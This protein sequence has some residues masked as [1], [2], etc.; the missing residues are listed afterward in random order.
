[1]DS[2]AGGVG[3]GVA[4]DLELIAVQLGGVGDEHDVLVPRHELALPGG[5]PHDQT[6]HAALDLLLH[7]RVVRREVHLAVWQVRGLD[8]GD[9]ARALDLVHA[10]GRLLHAAVGP[11]LGGLALGGE[12]HGEG[13]GGGGSKRCQ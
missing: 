10:R 5:A 1:M 11:F 8:G 12:R 2:L 7:E 6:L 9:E 3:A 4:D 13:L